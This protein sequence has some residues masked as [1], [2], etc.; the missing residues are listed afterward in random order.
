M[1]VYLDFLNDVLKGHT[2]LQFYMQTQRLISQIV[3][4]DKPALGQST[5]RKLS[6][7]HQHIKIERLIE[8]V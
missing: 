3:N 4:G 2:H 5:R 6:L 1:L 8:I 7:T